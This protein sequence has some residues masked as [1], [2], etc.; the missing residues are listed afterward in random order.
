VPIATGRLLFVLV[1]LAHE[2][3]RLVRLAVTEHPTAAWTRLPTIP[4]DAP[5]GGDTRGGPVQ[6]PEPMAFVAGTRTNL[7]GDSG[8]MTSRNCWIVH[9]A[10][11][12][13]G[14]FQWRIRRVPTSRT[15]NT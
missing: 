6:S 2:R 15:T 11:G 1:M 14:T 10:V 12:C 8:V 5:L 4:I 13:S 3:R 7:W 9:S